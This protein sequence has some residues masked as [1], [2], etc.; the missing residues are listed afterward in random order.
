MTIITITI[1][2]SI[3]SLAIVWTGH[4]LWQD[5]TNSR[6]SFTYRRYERL[7]DRVTLDSRLTAEGRKRRAH[8]AVCPDVSP[9]GRRCYQHTKPH[10]PCNVCGIPTAESEM[11]V[12]PETLR[13]QRQPHCGSCFSVDLAA[14]RSAR[15]SRT[16]ADWER[17]IPDQYSGPTRDLVRDFINSDALELVVDEYGPSA[18]SINGS[19]KTLGLGDLAYAELRSGLTVIRRTEHAT[20]GDGANR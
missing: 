4:Y 12:H 18:T 7:W 16:R 5:T 1:I 20:S 13:R 19:L 17:P 15:Q 11:K 9:S 8:A 2:T 3:V 6:G 10:R 14:Q